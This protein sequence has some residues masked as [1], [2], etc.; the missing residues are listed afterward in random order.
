MLRCVTFY[1]ITLLS[2]AVRLGLMH[3]GIRLG[4]AVSG[5][6]VGGSGG[7]GVLRVGDAP[8]NPWKVSSGCSLEGPST[9]QIH[10]PHGGDLIKSHH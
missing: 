3:Q 7:V 5:C 4:G 2:C 9:V 1:L 10:L 6:S 8:W